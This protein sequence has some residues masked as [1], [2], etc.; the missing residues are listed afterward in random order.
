MNESC[1]VPIGAAKPGAAKASC[2]A[3]PG[4]TKPC[5]FATARLCL[6]VAICLDCACGLPARVGGTWAE[7][8]LTRRGEAGPPTTPGY[9]AVGAA[10]DT[11]ATDLADGMSPSYAPVAGMGSAAT[12]L[13]DGMPP[14]KAA[15][16]TGIPGT[17]ITAGMPPGIAER[18]PPGYAAVGTGTGAT[19]VVDGKLGRGE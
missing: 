2:G 19:G 9:G 18:M 7:K 12:G 4:A 1:G 6:G 17:G 8:P 3:T 5:A 13:G 10:E 15:A 16:G 11:E 14:G